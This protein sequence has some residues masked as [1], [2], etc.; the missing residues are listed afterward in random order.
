MNMV[1]NLISSPLVL[2]TITFSTHEHLPNPIALYSSTLL[3]ICH[4]PSEL[5]SSPDLTTFYTILIWQNNPSSR[6]EK[7]LWWKYKSGFQN[8]VYRAY[9]P[10]HV[11]LGPIIRRDRPRS[12]PYSASIS[13]SHYDWST[14]TQ[15]SPQAS[16]EPAV[17]SQDS[18]ASLSISPGT[19]LSIFSPELMC[20][21]SW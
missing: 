6:Q 13:G 7:G 12:A 9:G 4:F 19:G 11:G 1:R 20:F 3:F 15:S 16:M 8:K 5:H 17:L 2:S 18:S 14:S 21:Q 10:G